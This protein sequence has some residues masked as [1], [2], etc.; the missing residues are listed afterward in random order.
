MAEQY[1]RSGEEGSR[2]EKARA[3]A[4]EVKDRTE[5]K[6]ESLASEARDR[7]EEALHEGKEK[8]RELGDEAG[9]RARTRAE[10]QKAR[11]S[12]GMRTMADALRHGTDQL[13]EDRRQY[14]GFLETVADRVEGASRYL[15]DRDM[16][17]VTRDVRGFA[18]DHTTMFLG[19]AFALGLAGA[20]FLK[21][22]G[23]EAGGDGGSGRG[24]GLDT[25]G[26]SQREPVRAEER[27]GYEQPV[28]QP[29]R[30]PAAR[31]YP[32][33]STVRQAAERTQEEGGYA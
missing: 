22:S 21:S 9:R 2:T 20:R 15:D 23:S 11:V 32:R 3:K 13:P 12:E 6:A 24:Q 29:P 8:A 1:G 17:D 7:G 25:S 28:R 18:R 26:A 31:P 30:D 10:E 5:A 14:G 16:E 4:R 27:P 19:G 33:S